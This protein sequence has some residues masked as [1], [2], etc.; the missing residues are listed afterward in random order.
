MNAETTLALVRE[1]SENATL[2][3]AENR[4]RLTRPQPAAARR[5][6]IAYE[7]QQTI[8]IHGTARTAGDFRRRV[9]PSVSPLAETAHAAQFTGSYMTF[10]KRP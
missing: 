6:I 8:R 10:A 9:H 5:E 1:L 4:L 3:P 2:R 7:D